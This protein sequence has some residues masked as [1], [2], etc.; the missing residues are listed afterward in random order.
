MK[1]ILSI[2]MLVSI[3]IATKGQIGIHTPT[4]KSSLHINGDM[5]L[6]STLKIGGNSAMAGNSG[7]SGN[8]LQSQGAGLS[9]VWKATEAVITPVTYSVTQTGTQFLPLGFNM[10]WLDIPGLSRTV[11]IP[12]GKKALI[13]ITGQQCFRQTKNI[14]KLTGISVGLFNGTPNPL[15]PIIS[16]TGQLVSQIATGTPQE[17]TLLP[18]TYSEI[19]DA[20]AVE[21]TRVYNIKAR[22]NY[23]SS[24]ADDTQDIQAVNDPMGVGDYS[25]MR[26]SLMI[27]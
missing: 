21:V 3:Y 16:Y 26:I 24:G 12:Q 2:C 14:R 1:N 7:N 18:I 13:I 5:T 4:P 8:I 10:P 20:T 25:Q 6:T 17:F 19:I 11:T 23:A 22:V 15:D 27:F 9:P